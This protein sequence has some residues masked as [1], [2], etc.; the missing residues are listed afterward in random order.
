[1]NSN[2][3]IL[4]VDHVSKRYRYGQYSAKTFQQAFK[5]WMNGIADPSVRSVPRADKNTFYALKDINLSITPGERLGIIGRNGAGKSTLLKLISRITSPTDGT[6]EL[7]GRV[8]SLLEVGTGFDSELTGRENIYLNGSILGMDRREIDEKIDDIISFSEV[9]D[10][11]DTPVKRYSSGMFVKLG[12]AVAA[13]LDNEIL[14]MDEVLAVGD[15][16]FQKKCLNRMNQIARDEGRTILYV[17]HNMN[18][19]KS[20][21]TRCIVLDKGR[22]IFDGDVD[23]AIALY[24]GLEQE[25]PPSYHYTKEYRPYDTVLRAN[26]RFEMTDL[27]FPT[28][29][30]FVFSESKPQDFLLSVH[31]DMDFER[32]GFRFELWYQDGLKAG[33]MLTEN[34]VR[35]PQGETDILLHF[36]PS[37]L[38]EGQYRADLIAYQFD[39]N[40]NEDILDGVYPGFIFQIHNEL[41]DRNHL[42]WHAQYWGPIHLH[43]L[44]ASVA[45]KE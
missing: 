41:D 1:M 17:S 45:E 5:N 25:L 13:Y 44:S 22:I 14:I 24:L 19:I 37:H 38:V 43:D 6:I 32:V 30:S 27:S 21:C 11:I 42:D 18:T 2:E 8:A 40:G 29:S 23:K 31:S 3:L 33:S 4:R 16:D 28:S 7:W 10:F 26:K 36:D 12:F 20:L 34:F 15:L 9:G 35:I 39:S